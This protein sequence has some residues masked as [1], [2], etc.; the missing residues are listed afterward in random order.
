MP[1]VPVAAR[2]AKQSHS[3]V[4]PSEFRDAA[5]RFESGDSTGAVVALRAFLARHPQDERAEDASYLL[6]LALRQI[7]DKSG[8]RHAARAYLERYPAGFRRSEVEVLARSD[9]P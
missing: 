9:E 4:A 3:D 8:S 1:A 2:S 6:V 7:G 5:G